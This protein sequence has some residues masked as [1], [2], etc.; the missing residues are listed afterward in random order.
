MRS[1][2]LII[3]SVCVILLYSLRS[4][5]NITDEENEFGKLIEINNG[6]IKKG[7]YENAL[8]YLKNI[9]LNNEE[10]WNGRIV[11][12]DYS[13]I[14]LAKNIV[15]FNKDALLKNEI[16]IMLSKLV[17]IQNLESYNRAYNYFSIGII[18]SYIEDYV[19]SVKYLRLS[20]NEFENLNNEEYLT[21]NASALSLA[22]SKLNDYAKAELFINKALTHLKKSKQIADVNKFDIWYSSAINSFKSKKYLLTMERLDSAFKFVNNNGNDIKADLY[23]CYGLTYSKLN[24]FNKAEENFNKAIL[25]RN[26][27]KPINYQNLSKDYQNYS[28][29]LSKMGRTK[30]AI[31]MGKKSC[32]LIEQ[33]LVLKC[34]SVSLAYSSLG[35]ILLENNY[36]YEA[37]E[38]YNKALLSSSSDSLILPKSLFPDSSSIIYLPEY[39][40]ALKGKALV[41]KVLSEHTELKKEEILK[42]SLVCYRKAI[43][44]L[45]KLRNNVQFDEG[46]FVI[47]ENER[48]LYNEAVEVCYT[49]YKLTNNKV[50][51]DIAFDIIER[52]KAAVLSE[53][54]SLLSNLSENSEFHTLFTF[55]Q[56]LKNEISIWEKIISENEI[57]TSYNK[58]KAILF[59][60]YEIQEK[61]LTL[62]KSEYPEY[63]QTWLFPSYISISQFQSKLNNEEAFIDYYFNDSA[64]FSIVISNDNKSFNKVYCK[65]SSVYEKVTDFRKKISV[66]DLESSIPKGYNSFKNQSF[67]LYSLLLQPIKSQT[68]KKSIIISTDGILNYLP[69][70][71]LIQS[72]ELSNEVDYRKLNYMLIDYQISYAYSATIYNS[73]FN[74]NNNYKKDLLAVVPDYSTLHSQSNKI[75]SNKENT[76]L[77]GA[78]KEVEIIT[79]IVK[80]DVL[81]GIQASESIFKKD[82][83]EYAILHLAMHGEIDNSDPLNSRLIFEKTNDKEDGF[84]YTWEI[85]NMHLKSAL[86]VLSACNTGTGK[87][88]DG[89]GVMS[90]ARAFTYAGCPS[91]IM[92]LWSVSDLSSTNIME[93]FY[94]FLSKGNNKSEA[95]QKAKI[96]YILDSSPAN[97]HPYYWAGY[98]MIGNKSPIEFNSVN[99]TILL[100][101]VSLS[102]L[103]FVIIIF[104]RYKR[105][106]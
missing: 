42:Q 26:I 79:S 81:C 65:Y 3:I 83:S 60:L 10:E 30:E 78:K 76:F 29:L 31:K 14:I 58:Q 40:R 101:V 39:I 74:S 35:S 64:L 15:E 71:A 27:E 73:K 33:V 1:I 90:L 91:V 69:F 68:N 88:R 12:I 106:F 32:E 97:S 17:S 16:K 21:Y 100:I 89:E 22:Y 75:V 105:S 5:C 92:T 37:I 47:S 11:E 61:F 7:Q 59:D 96:N 20:Y 50:Y 45:E 53:K 49:L 84:L 46:Q 38:A 36:Y 9:I 54:V 77:K 95:L 6:L 4:L 86:I 2:I 48:E 98:V 55:N 23:D 102:A 82:A 66:F 70:E 99:K 57:I 103:L 18:S 43:S 41:L 80:G 19:N 8:Y 24:Q 72:N 28:E 87:I 34:G 94:R 62:I 44:Q 63:Y 52:S 13:L 93:S 25:Y 67:N 56:K 51:V 85:Y 104:Y